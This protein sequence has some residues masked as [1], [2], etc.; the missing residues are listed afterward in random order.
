MMEWKTI[1]G[2][3]FFIIVIVLLGFYWIVPFDET[4]F[5]FKEKNY[6]FSLNESNNSG[7]QFYQRMRFPSSN[8][9]YKIEDCPLGKKED[10]E[11][12]FVIISEKT[13]LS[14]YAIESKEEIFVTCDS[15]NKMEGELFIAGEGGPTNIT[16]TSNFNVIKNGAITL[17]RESQCENPNVGIH[18]LLHVLGFDHSPNPN[19][20][21]YE[22]S[23]CN[24]E[25]S[26]DIIDTINDLYSTPSYADL[27]MENASAVMH[28]K[29]LDAS[30]IVTNN[31]LKD[32]RHSTV[33]IYADNEMV[34]EFEMEELQIGYGRKIT[35]QNIFILQIS[36]DR[37]KF[38]VSYDQPELNKEDNEIILDIKK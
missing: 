24:Q 31:G 3:L 19:N 8:I 1:F 13:I 38:V 20:I 25:I 36:V 5:G 27:S 6:N 11:R 17:I 10:M 33:R 12:A 26:Q 34:K 7:M 18:E 16:K 35:L 23:R 9:S 2:L 29:Y 22:L 4:D 14:F 21:M 30:F 15:M 37:L 28:G 32:S